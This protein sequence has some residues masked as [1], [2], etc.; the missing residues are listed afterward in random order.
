MLRDLTNVNA[1][2]VSIIF[3]R[4][5]QSEEVPEYWKKPNVTPV[6]K[7]GK[8]EDAGNYRLVSF[9]LILGNLMKQMILETLFKHIKDKNLIRRHQ[10]GF[11]KGKSYFN[12]LRTVYD[13]MTSL[14]GEEREVDTVSLDINKAFDT[15]FHNILIDKLI[16]H[17]LNKW[18][19][20]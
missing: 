18:T 19:M 17:R 9:T 4:L 8:K 7:E 13:E 14:V 11:M 1:R 3:E 20:R 10:H 6:F 16:K 5:Y 12:N 2:P 15:V